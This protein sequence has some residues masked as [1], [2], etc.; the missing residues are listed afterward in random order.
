MINI[1]KHIKIKVILLIIATVIMPLKA[2]SIDT[3]QDYALDTITGKN[4]MTYHV[5]AIYSDGTEEDITSLSDVTYSTSGLCTATNG[6]ITGL[7]YGKVNIGF[8][9]NGETDNFPLIIENVEAERTV[10]SIAF[11]P[12][13][14]NLQIGQNASFTCNAIYKDGHQQDIS[15]VGVFKADNANVIKLLGDSVISVGKGTANITVSYKGVYGSLV[16][17]TLPVTVTYLNPYVKNEAENYTAQSGVQCETLTA[18]DKNVAF[19]ENR[20]WVE[21]EGMDFGDNGPSAFSIIAATPNS[22]GYVRVYANDV[23]IA[24]CPVTNS[25]GWSTWKAYRCKT[26]KVTGVNKIRLVFTG[27][28][29]YLFNINSWIF[30]EETSGINNINA[31]TEDKSYYTTSG[32]N[33][34]TSAKALPKGIYIHSKRK[35]VI[36]NNNR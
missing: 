7:N 29:G 8:T 17:G 1:L 33:A 10:S 28:S 19:I 31:D 2:L 34:G 9:Y 6:T 5:T 30:T 25:G 14:L 15:S 13:S 36:S 22:G 32:I 4:T 12:S 18:T 21:Y 16:T 26:N 24:T 23:L 3:Y 27:G 35:V 20:N 11:S